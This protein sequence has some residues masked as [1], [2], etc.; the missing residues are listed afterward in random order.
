M[1]HIFRGFD[2]N[3]EKRMVVAVGDRPTPARRRGGPGGVSGGRP[4]WVGL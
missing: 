3:Q 4:G 2:E 1:F